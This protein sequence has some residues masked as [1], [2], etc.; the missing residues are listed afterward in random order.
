MTT[1]TQKAPGIRKI[2]RERRVPRSNPARTE[3]VIEWEARVSLGLH[4][5]RP[6]KAHKVA[7]WFWAGDGYPLRCECG[8]PLGDEVQRKLQKTATRATRGEAEAWR[9]KTRA[10]HHNGVSPFTKPAPTKTTVSAYTVG[11]LAARRP[12]LDANTYVGYKR[13]LTTLADTIG[14]VAL[15]ELTVAQ[16]R[17]A[18]AEYRRT[19]GRGGKGRTAS[20]TRQAKVILSGML[21]RAVEDGLAPY[22]AARDITVTVKTT[23]VAVPDYEDVLGLLDHCTEGDEIW[24]L[25]LA[26]AIA[27]G[28]RR[29]E[30]LG[31]LRRNVS[32]DGDA[33][34]ITIDGVWRQNHDTGSLERRAGSK[35]DASNDSL[36]VEW[37]PAVLLLRAAMNRTRRLDAETDF[38]CADEA[39]A[40]PHPDSFGKAFKRVAQRAGLG[41]KVTLHGGTRHAVATYMAEQGESGAVIARQLRHADGGA[42]AQRVYVKGTSKLQQRAASVL[43]GAARSA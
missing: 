30:V 38:V 39:G 32:F 23:D 13:T 9:D 20:S 19:G 24:R 34:K 10:D 22:N 27:T 15:D 5:A 2:E 41:D 35:S 11:Y 33:A 14:T 4:P 12:E 37:A 31:L 26:L 16:V 42:L 25:P 8:E 28:A 17:A 40:M 29:G 18:L 43:A 36:R 6:C 21:K 1:K 3:R 7:R